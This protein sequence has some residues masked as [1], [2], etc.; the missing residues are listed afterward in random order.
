[1]P[2]THLEFGGPEA[3]LGR[4]NFHREE[5]Y[6]RAEAFL[7]GEGAAGD[8][9][10]VL[11]L[12]ADVRGAGRGYF[13]DA[14]AF[15]LRHEELAP[16][17]WH[18]DLSGFEPDHPQAI[19]AYLGYQLEKRQARLAG[20]KDALLKIAG[21][22]SQWVAPTELG[23]TLVA[24]VLELG[25]P[26]QAFEKLLASEAESL[27]DPARRPEEAL[28]RVLA[29]LSE[30]QRVVLHVV[31]FAQL[32][33]TMRLH[34]VELAEKTPRVF[35][36]FSC[37]GENDRQVAPQ[38]RYAVLRVEID[39]LSQPELR[40]LIDMRLR[41][42]DL[43]DELIE[44]VWR[45]TG[46]IPARVGARMAELVAAGAIVDGDGGWSLHEKGLTAEELAERFRG[47]IDDQLNTFF[48]E[49]GDNALPL[50]NLL[51]LGALCGDVFLP[52]LFLEL[53]D[54]I[55]DEEHADTLIDAIDDVLVAELGWIEDLEFRHPG[56]PGM[57]VY[58]FAHP[59]LA[60]ALQQKVG[61]AGASRIAKDLREALEKRLPAWTLAAGRLHLALCR[62]L[63]P[64]YQKPVLE[65]LTWWVGQ[66]ESAQ[67]EQRVREKIESREID[68]EL[69]WNL[70]FQTRQKWPPYRRL[71][72]LDAYAGAQVNTPLPGQGRSVRVSNLP[73]ER[74][75]LYV[76][77]R[78][79]LLLA[80]GRL[81]EA[82]EAAAS[83]VG[84]L[85]EK[86]EEL[87]AFLAASHLH[88]LTLAAAG[89]TE[90]ARS[91]LAAAY[92]QSFALEDETIQQR[93]AAALAQVS[94]PAPEN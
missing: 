45:A 72:L 76:F 11:V 26:V 18:L 46:G 75:P 33:E 8:G 93:L 41:P 70:V 90:E 9:P 77:E 53:M 19:L 56:F 69:V 44:A 86:D 54:G 66:E 83:A 51:V 42:N 65:Q 79:H 63:A 62:H 40:L 38:A 31:D 78:G 59:A 94:Q 28:A 32:T 20:Q 7:R 57:Q 85:A 87:E 3:R 36:A 15:R 67:L 34:L 10:S 84:L 29:E 68:G 60:G 49:Q 43:P 88:G 14:L 61:A 5:D 24:L 39:P 22:L 13:L 73:V 64:A 47:E 30:T 16:M 25:D 58:R 48:V 81:D 23:A 21:P 2:W 55:E 35:V 6:L 17:V 27:Q 1:M 52:K 71:A 50:R 4:F 92:D 74:T 89:R 82:V 80:L 91:V 37:Y 12:S